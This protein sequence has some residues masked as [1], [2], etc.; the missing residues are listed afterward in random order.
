MY[1]TRALILR[2]E[3]RGEADVLV[4][5]LAEDFGKIRL[6]AQGA[7]K[8][9]A[10][11]KGH[12]EPGSLA[13]I[14]FVVGKNGY[15]LTTAELKNFFL[16]LRRSLPKLRALYS[17]LTLLDANLFEE[18]ERA[19]ELFSL[20]GETLAGLGFADREEILRRAVGWFY[21][22]FFDFLGVLPPVDALEAAGS[23]ALVG[24]GTRPLAE[25]IR[26]VGE[27]DR[28]DRELAELCRQLR[29]TIRAAW[30]GD[31]LDL[32]VY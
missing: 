10:K 12:L 19:P 23:R 27:P 14:S 6:L 3:E 18:R 20:V 26:E 16:P 30:P 1:H 5:A 4:T 21:V 28:F 7:R 24:L 9:Q 8:H 32:A 22:R 11:L 15:R 29:G 25:V 2:R 31:G 13:S 17:V